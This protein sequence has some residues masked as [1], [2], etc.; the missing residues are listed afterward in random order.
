ME[1]G[2]TST[3]FYLASVLG[4][5]AVYMM[6]PR[7]GYSPRRMGALLGAMTL[8]GLWLY[9]SKHLP[10]ALGI[11]SIAF[12][13][14]YVFSGLAIAS[15]VKVITHSKPVFSA[16]WFVMLVLA[17]SGLLLVLEAEFTAIAMV[18]IYG[19]AILVTY[20]FV[21]MLAAQAGDPQSEASGAEYDQIAFEP[22]AAVTAGFLLLA[23]LLSAVFD[24]S[25]HG[26]APATSRHSDLAAAAALLTDRPA[27]R[28]AEK[29]TATE[30]A[31]LTVADP[32]VYGTDDQTVIAMTNTERVGLDLFRGHPLG[33]E[34]AGVVLLV[35]L[36]GAVV[37]AR[38]HVTSSTDDGAQAP[39]DPVGDPESIPGAA[40]HA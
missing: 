5:L 22:V 20:L 40:V 6:M 13:Y 15:G 28:L 21:I 34:L 11:D 33:L 19:G 37:I 16:L 39:N 2:V 7:R 38:R 3:A 17:A 10:D 26:L 12:S 24:V 32:Q 31:Q 27:S 36:I 25:P 14:H 4:A 35:S 1:T 23:V 30:A 8:G 29:L 9:L 18:I